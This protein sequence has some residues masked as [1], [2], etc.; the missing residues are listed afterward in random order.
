[1]EVI[2][3]DK[4]KKDT[5]MLKTLLNMF[6]R[7]QINKDNP[8]QR[9]PDQWS[10]SMQG[11]L[12]T[13]VIKGEDIDPIKLCEQLIGNLWIVWLIDG[14]QRLT[15]LEKYSNN[16]FPISKKQKLPY[17]YYQKIGENGEREVVEYDLR[18]KYYSDL[19]DELKDAFDSYPIEVVKQLNCTNEDVA[20]HIERYDQQKNMNT[21][22][23]GILSMGKVA[24]Y[25]KDISK[26]QPFFKS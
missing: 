1:M 6:K 21:N 4:C 18:G 19:P 15:T 3:R 16:A 23:K 8:L 2:G 11:W 14:L 24:C 10:L 20:Y 5:Y 26:K 13:S 22:Q 7:K 9:E 25:I 17:V 12:V